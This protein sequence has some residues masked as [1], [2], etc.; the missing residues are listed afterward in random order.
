VLRLI[1]NIYRYERAMKKFDRED[2]AEN[3]LTIRNDKIRSLIDELFS[4]TS[5]ALTSGAV[6]KDSSFAGAISYMH[7]LG[8]ALYSFLEN[9]YLQPDNGESERALRAFTIGRKNWMFLG[10]CSGGEAAG[11]LMSL[12][13]T[14]RRMD[15]DVFSY[16]D[17]VLRRING[18]PH[19]KLHELL[20][21]NWQKTD[22]YY[23]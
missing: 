8:K 19:S 11:I 16:L 10:S 23:K 20:P 7:K 18:H 9:P 13:Q 2:Q 6:M 17:D 14:C 15:I 22:S 1:R 21:G 12:V 3:I 4:I 5:K